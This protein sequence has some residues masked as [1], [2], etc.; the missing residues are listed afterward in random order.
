MINL[1][2]WNDWTKNTY[3]HV[4]NISGQWYKVVYLSACWEILSKEV[5]ISLLKIK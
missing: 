1:S 5:I 2:K 3:L 4:R